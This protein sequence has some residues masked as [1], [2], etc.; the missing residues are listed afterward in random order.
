MAASVLSM[1][2]EAA[3]NK[4][5]ILFAGP[6]RSGSASVEEFFQKYCKGSI[7]HD[8][9]SFALRYWK[10]PQIPQGHATPGVPP[11]KVFQN[12]VI[13]PSENDPLNRDII[14][15]IK[16][17]WETTEDGIVLG[18]EMFDQMGAYAQYD[19]LEAMKRIVDY[20]GLTDSPKQVTVVVNYRAPRLGHWA[21]V[22]KGTVQG[23]TTSYADFMCHTRQYH[24]KMEL[25]STAVNPLQVALES[26]KLGWNVAL[27]DMKGIDDAGLDVTHT[28]ACNIMDAKCSQSD[29]WVNHHIE[30]AIHNNEAEDGHDLIELTDKQRQEAEELL[31]ARDCAYGTLM[32]KLSDDPEAGSFK[33]YSGASLWQHCDPDFSEGPYQNLLNPELVFRGLLSQLKCNEVIY[34]DM[35]RSIQDILYG[36]F[37]LD[38]KSTSVLADGTVKNKKKKHH[39]FLWV[40]LLAGV[41]VGLSIH[42]NNG[43]VPAAWLV[44]AENAKIA[45]LQLLDAA[46]HRMNG[47]GGPQTEMESMD[48][49]H[50]PTTTLSGEVS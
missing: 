39:F 2:A 47:G 48:F 16:D 11:Y 5:L 9:D 10:W 28:I 22:W 14:A 44:S 33:V 3:E 50:R 31:L 41:Y 7:R 17:A 42:K 34:S 32:K 12:L 45:T 4:R 49:N 43:R 15:G 40:F 25:L 26:Q 6:H 27:M 36:K 20:V 13:E 8:K 19:G 23:T 29:G 24:E 1:A 18:T 35:P 21:S 37:K 30:E 38:E 46:K